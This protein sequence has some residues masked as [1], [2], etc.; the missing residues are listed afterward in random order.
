MRPLLLLA[1]L[2][3][4]VVAEPRWWKGNTHAHTLWSDGNDFPEMVVDWY[5]KH[6]YHF[7]ALSD[8]NIVADHEKWMPMKTIVSR[9]RGKHAYAKYRERFGGDWV[10]IRKK[11]D[12]QQVRLKTLDEFRPLFEKSGEFLL[13]RGEEITDRF[14]KHEIHINAVNLKSKIKPQHGK[15]VRETIRNN[16]LAIREHERKTGQPVL[17]HVNH[18]NFRWSLTAEDLA[19]VLE[20]EF[21]EVYNGHPSVH[22]FGKG[23]R[24]GVERLWDIANTIRLGEL[25]APPLLGVATD[26]SHQYHGGN[27]SPGKGWIMVRAGELSADALIAAMRKGDFYASTGVVLRD[28]RF[29]DGTLT[30]EIER[31]DNAQFETRFYGTLKGYDA[32][33]RPTVDNNGNEVKTTRTYSGDVGR[34][35]AVKQGRRVS[36]RLTGQELYVRATITSTRTV[37]NP[38]YKDQVKQAWT[39]PVGWR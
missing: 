25:K 16:L 4:T 17:A 7:L 23:V 10:E 37:E 6:G 24:A 5:V 33:S 13:I 36:Y 2:A 34:V 19:H 11:D 12:K 21:F 8:H 18:P 30:I 22:S 29:A 32:T 9:A 15:S 28:V 39:Q 3:S 27:T 26:D 31:D 14:E 1:L 35:L 38:T 20:E